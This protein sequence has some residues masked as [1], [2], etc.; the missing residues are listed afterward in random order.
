MTLQPHE[1]FINLASEYKL[2]PCPQ[3]IGIHPPPPAR[4]TPATTC[5][6]C[7][8]PPT[9]YVNLNL[10]ANLLGCLAENREPFPYVNQPCLQTNFIPSLPHHPSHLHK[11]YMTFVILPGTRPRTLDLCFYHYTLQ[12]GT[13]LTTWTLP[14]YCYSIKLFHIK[15]S[16]SKPC[17]CRNPTVVL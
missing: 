8:P 11:T 1:W 16:F 3:L 6:Q 10:Q 14:A 15:H 12:H 9:Q 13:R 7:Y 2:Y 4:Q 17:N 5:T